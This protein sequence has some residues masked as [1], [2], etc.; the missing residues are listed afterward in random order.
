MV[1][2]ASALPLAREV[3]PA[4]AKQIVIVLAAQR[5]ISSAG[6]VRL[7]ESQTDLAIAVVAEDLGAAARYA[8]GH[9]PDV[10]LLDAVTRNACDQA[11]QV[12]NELKDRSPETATVLLTLLED[13]LAIRDVL[14]DGALG[15]VLSSDDPEQLFEAIRHA[16]VRQPY[17][18]PTA[19]VALAGLH[20]RGDATSLTDR[21]MEVLRLVGLGHTNVEIAGLMHLSVRTVESHRA[22]LQDKLAAVSRADVVREAIDRGLVN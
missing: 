6:L 1:K 3:T 19:S 9:K 5:G 15:Y 17:L 7:I 18:S 8:A 20:S 21:E 22:H 10:V 2:T 16:A 14:R 4:P 11:R 13:P 12:I